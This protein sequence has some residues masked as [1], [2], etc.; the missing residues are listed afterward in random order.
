MG[1]PVR[2]VARALDRPGAAVAFSLAV[3][4][5]DF[6]LLAPLGA[7]VLRAFLERWGRASVGNFEIAAFLL[8]PPGV[9][10]LVA[11]AGLLAATLYL[12]V[13]GLMRLLADRHL[14][15]GRGLAAAAGQFPKLVALGVT[16]AAAYLT[17]ALPFLVGIGLVALVFWSGRDPNSLL[18]LRP[19]EFW[20]G[21]GVAAVLVLG[22]AALAGRLFVHWLFALPILLFEPVGVGQALR[23]STERTR[24]KAW[25]LAGA[26]AAWAAGFAAVNAAALGGLGGAAGWALDRVGTA[27]AVAV[28]ATATVLLVQFAAATLLGVAG[29]VTFAA[30]VLARYEESAPRP[31]PAGDPAPANRVR[32]RR[33]VP[34][35]LLGAAA[36]VAWQS[37]SLIHGV[38]LADGV[39]VTAHR[40]GATHAPENT[41]AA[42]RRAIADGADWAEIDVMLTADGALVVTHDTDLS[43]SGGGTKRVR[44]ATLAEIRALDIGSKFGPEFAGEKIPTFDEILTAAGDRIRLNVELKPHGAAGV[45]PLTTRVAAAI[46]V[47][48]MVERCRICSQSYEALQLSRSLEP[49]MKV[50]FIAGAAVGDLTA[51]DVDF[52][53]VEARKATRRLSD[54]AAARGVAVHAWTV[55]DPALLAPLID[56]GVVNVITDDTPAMVGRLAELR[57]LDPVER[58]ILRVR[59]AWAD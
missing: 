41:V 31:T 50:G 38:R 24:G 56:R 2:G 26:L 5:L 13:A 23:L 12:E 57:E 37:Y 55:D 17:L 44:D 14:G 32:L 47:A 35:A 19:P 11:A 49:R 40:A 6:V 48:G 42:L 53:M 1:N 36:V 30:V 8:S 29:T 7:A 27:P 59:N 54:R 16:Q 25:P 9:L 20:A 4:V 46:R 52:L 39:E 22:Y 3:K 34:P 21:A 18:L 15:W 51:L 45:E 58:V 43:R 28:P 33:W 10:A